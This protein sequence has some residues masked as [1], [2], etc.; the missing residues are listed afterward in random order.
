MPRSL[1]CMADL[2]CRPALANIVLALSL[3]YL[4][5]A[6]IVVLELI[7]QCKSNSPL[8]RVLLTLLKVF[9]GEICDGVYVDDL[10][11]STNDPIIAPW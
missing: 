4:L 11:S 9:N 7:L 8:I 10:M 1:A 6:S 3:K 2:A 5:E